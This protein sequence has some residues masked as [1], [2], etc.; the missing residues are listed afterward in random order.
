MSTAARTVRARRGRVMIVGD[1]PELVAAAGQLQFTSGAPLI[2]P[3]LFDALGE[4]AISTATTPVTTVL[5]SERC[6]NGGSPHAAEA[7]RK[8]DPALR[9]VLI[10]HEAPGSAPEPAAAASWIN[11]GF[12]DC[13]AVPFGP[14][15]LARLFED[16]LLSPAGAGQPSEPLRLVEQADT[17]PA[18]LS[19]GEKRESVP[20]VSLDALRAKLAA[21]VD[22]IAEVEGGD[23]A[24]P[25]RAGSQATIDVSHSPKRPA[26]KPSP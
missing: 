21:P 15:E 26:P 6:V 16:D 1:V 25:S 8:L 24:K 20:A 19:S 13:I 7:L 12:D 10:K 14:A 2:A 4:V 23:W 17:T 11:R 9:L 3:N 22:L 5:L 18:E